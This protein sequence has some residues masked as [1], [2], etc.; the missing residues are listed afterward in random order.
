MSTNQYLAE[1]QGLTNKVERLENE[2][3]ELQIYRAYCLYQMGAYMNICTEENGL[4][5]LSFSEWR[6][7]KQIEECRQQL[8]TG[9][10]Q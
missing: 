6:W 9:S 7:R 10:N 8:L 5:P 1:I 3:K 2:V 4:H